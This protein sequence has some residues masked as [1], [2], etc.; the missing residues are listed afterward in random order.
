MNL[1]FKEG[2][3]SDKR[4]KL[5]FVLSFTQQTNKESVKI[6]KQVKNS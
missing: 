4:N 2:V 5:E 3:V 1:W 6:Y